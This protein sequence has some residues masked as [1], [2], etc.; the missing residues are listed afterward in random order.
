MYIPSVVEIVQLGVS[1]SHASQGFSDQLEVGAVLAAN[2]DGLD[3]G[4]DAFLVSL[5]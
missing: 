4:V 3:A 2:V 1:L 5:L